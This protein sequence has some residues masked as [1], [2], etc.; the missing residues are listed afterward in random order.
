MITTSQGVG[1]VQVAVVV[2]AVVLLQ[3]LRRLGLQSLL[4]K[5]V[6]LVL[7]QAHRLVELRAL[8]R[9]AVV[10]AAAVALQTVSGS[11]HGC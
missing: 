10:A 11:Q 7:Q 5:V 8:P 4:R 1:A 3:P 9:R 6:V 2:A